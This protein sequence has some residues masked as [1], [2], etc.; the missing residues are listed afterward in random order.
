MRKLVLANS[1]L[2][3]LCGKPATV[4]DH[5]NPITLNNLSQFF[6]YTNLQSLCNRCHRIKTLNDRGIDSRFSRL[7][8]GKEIKESLEQ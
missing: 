2:C 8:E 1:P 3:K 6:E 7:K 5:I 4:V